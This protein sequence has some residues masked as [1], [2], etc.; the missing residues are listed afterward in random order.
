M[1]DKNSVLENYIN[2]EL[3][4]EMKEYAKKLIRK[5]ERCEKPFRVTSIRS[6]KIWCSDS[7]RNRNSELKRMKAGEK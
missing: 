2:S 5:C 6:R 1:K 4:R 3:S 7:C